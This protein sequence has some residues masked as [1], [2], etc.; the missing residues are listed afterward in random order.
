MQGLQVIVRK[1]QEGATG[2]VGKSQSQSSKASWLD[3]KSDTHP[4]RTLFTHFA[5][6]QTAMTY[7][8]LRYGDA[9]DDVM[10]HRGCF[11]LRGRDDLIETGTGIKSSANWDDLEIAFWLFY[12]VL[13][14]FYLFHE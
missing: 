13:C 14:C 8:K 5:S 7:S 4:S 3:Q 11:I 1:L 2:R 6:N 12:G 9:L 10:L